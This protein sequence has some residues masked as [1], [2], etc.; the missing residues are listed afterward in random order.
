MT[1]KIHYPGGKAGDGVY[2]AIINQIP[3]HDLYIEP[4][5]GGF[6]IGRHKRPTAASIAID[7]DGRAVETLRALGLPGVIVI[8]GD[9]ISL[10]PGCIADSGVPAGRVFVYADPPYL[11]SVRSDQARLYAHEFWTPEEHQT[12]LDLLKSLNCMV[13]LSGYW[14]EQYA[15]ELSSWRTVSFNA[16]VR[17]GAVRREWLWMNYPEPVALHDYAF[18]GDDYRERER[19]KRKMVRWR[20][21]LRKM[22][23]LERRAILWGLQEAGIIESVPR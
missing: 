23:V 5:A 1:D 4:F 13:M 18:M 8:H 9:A 21:R 17:S 7:A 22:D 14:S 19:I 3:P 2:Q 15:Q 11:R 16:V 10:L 12:L 20:E 6:A